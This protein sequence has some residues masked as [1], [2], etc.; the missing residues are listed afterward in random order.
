MFRLEG[1]TGVEFCN[2]S[3]LVDNK[4]MEQL[5]YERVEIAGC[6][7]KYGQNITAYF[8]KDDSQYVY[9][10]CYIAKLNA[11][12]KLI[13]DKSTFDKLDMKNRLI[14][15]NTGK[16]G[17]SG[18]RAVPYVWYNDKML[19]IHKC[20]HEGKEVDHK[21]MSLN[22]ITKESLREC[23]TTQNS[24][25][26][27]NLYTWGMYMDG[28]FYIRIEEN[29]GILSDIDIEELK[30]SGFSVKV[31]KKNIHIEK[32]FENEIDAIKELRAYEERYYGE[33]AYN[34]LNDMRGHIDAKIDQLILGTKTG[35]DVIREI[36]T[37]YANDAVLIARYNL[38]KEYESRGMDYN[39]G[40]ILENGRFVA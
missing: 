1:I 39:H 37:D 11:F 16:G 27:K 21:Q 40:N 32:D 22:L 7:G 20:G 36:L 2:E 19:A 8:Y 9:A 15:I 24:K 4:M 6:N 12:T 29:D 33:Y 13:I 3:E 30:Q 18:T 23:N 34:P 17:G 14:I 38:E 5:G 35:D 10:E 28:T 26:K 25:N 31:T